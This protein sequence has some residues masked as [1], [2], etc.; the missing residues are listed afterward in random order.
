MATFPQPAERPMTA[1][2]FLALPE[3]NQPCELREGRVVMAPAPGFDHQ[4]ILGNLYVLLREHLHSLGKGWSFVAPA[5]VRLS[6]KTVLQPDLLVTW[7]D[8]RGRK[9]HEGPP[10]LVVEITSPSSSLSDKKRKRRLYER[11]AVPYF[12]LIDSTNQTFEAFRWTEQGYVLA[13]QWQGE[14]TVAAKPF[15]EM[16]FRLATLWQM[17]PSETGA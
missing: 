3:S 5:D 12:W 6:D 15:P 11:H 8:M 4:T 10:Y 16:R 9:V 1:A 13:G 14:K 7:A 2:E 17:G